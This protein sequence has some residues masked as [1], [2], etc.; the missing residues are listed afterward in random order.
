MIRPGF[1]GIAIGT[2]LLC[3]TGWAQAISPTELFEKVRSA[4]GSLQ[5]YKAEGT[6]STDANTGGMSVKSEIS[7]SIRLRKPN[8]Y[9]ISWTQKMGMPGM[10]HSGAVWS[11]GTQAYLY[12]MNAYSKMTSDEMAL[13]AATGVSG[14][15]AFTIPAL[16]M[17]WL[18]NASDQFSRLNDLKIETGEKV[19]DDDCY[20][21]S[22]ASA[23]S[24]KETFWISKSRYLILKYSR[25]FESPEGGRVAP[26]LND[27]QLEASIKAMGQQVTEE[28]KQK[29]RAMLK[30]SAEILNK[31]QLKGWST[32]LHTGISSPEIS[33]Q[34]VTFKLPDG[35]VLKE[36]LFDGI[37]GGATDAAKHPKQ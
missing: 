7:F 36:S 11:D 27:E 10:S 13:A 20:V 16:F 24:R 35:A 12:M 3:A 19:G 21:V 37:M 8:L 17:P 32:E 4:Y 34:D 30:Q 6:I 33:K 18:M 23:G 26:E 22:G 5:T 15:A 14:G 2:F 1:I 9:L 31:S 28:N 29:M 25:S